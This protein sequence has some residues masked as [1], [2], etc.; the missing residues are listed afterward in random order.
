MK[1]QY[2]IQ[3][4]TLW[5]STPGNAL[6]AILNKLGSGKK[7]SIQSVQIQTVNSVGNPSLTT[8]G[9]N[10]TAALVHSIPPTFYCLRHNNKFGK[11]VSSRYVGKLDSNSPSL[12]SLNVSIE[13]EVPVFDTDV[14]TTHVEPSLSYTDSTVAVEDTTFTPDISPSWIANVHRDHERWFYVSSGNN[15]GL[16]R[17]I[18]NT[19]TALTLDPPLYQAG[20]TT[21]SIVKFKDVIRR[22]KVGK[23][24]ST[25]TT[26]PQ[27][28]KNGFLN[29]NRE[30]VSSFFSFVKN[31]QPFTIQENESFSIIAPAPTLTTP[32]ILT[33][34]FYVNT[35]IN[36]Y[37]YTVSALVGVVGWNESLLTI[38]NTGS[39]TVGITNVF[40]TEIGS[41]DTPYFQIV[42]IQSIDAGVLNDPLRLNEFSLVKL[43]STFTSDLSQILT[44]VSD[45]YVLPYGVPAVY[46]SEG[47]S[48]SPK[49]FNYLQT[50][51]FLGPTFGTLFPEKVFSKMCAT[52]A[53]N[54]SSD[55]GLSLSLKSFIRPFLKSNIQLLEGDGIAIVSG[56]ETAIGSQFV[57]IGHS[58]WGLYQFSVIITI[59]N[60]TTPHLVLTG[61]PENSEVCVINAQ[62]D[63][64]LIDEEN[65]SGTFDWIYEYTPGFSVHINIVNLGYQVL[66]LSNIS[67]TSSGL[68]IPIQLIPDRVYL[69]P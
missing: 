34:Q 61:L 3:G 28:F 26:F 44:I 63:Q 17:I 27:F 24:F 10:F 7:I 41:T 12:S 8:G 2:I 69:N 55:F 35:G 43:D 42:P 64:I 50:K 1:E 54:G 29:I 45:T 21:G 13:Y 68:T 48:G 62:T 51:D 20:A 14:L 40:F 15:Q 46:I 33:V 36:K 39:Y 6:I 58:G 57:G 65:V 31:S 37:A 25:A 60:A 11:E 23:N 56:A 9:T 52:V 32:G 30:R 18:G 19:A 53:D 16:Y 59:E 66:R 38:K 47:S 22:L 5:S 4:K 49:G 67:L